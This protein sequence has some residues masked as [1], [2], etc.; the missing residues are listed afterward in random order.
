[1]NIEHLAEMVNDIAN[2]F[3]IE[4]DR[5]VAIDSVSNHLRKFWD[6]RM[7]R[8]IIAYVRDQGAG[9]MSELARAGVEKLATIDPVAV[10]KSA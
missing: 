3:A 10:A 8:Q 2:F 6:P 9:G 4:P 7:R 1:M 5:N